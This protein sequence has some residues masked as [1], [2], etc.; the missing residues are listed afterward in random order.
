MRLFLG[1]DTKGREPLISEVRFY[2]EGGD[3]PEIPHHDMFKPFRFHRGLL[4]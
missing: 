1:I 4:G 3:A 2:R